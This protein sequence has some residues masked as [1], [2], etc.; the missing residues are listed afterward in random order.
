MSAAFLIQLVISAVAVA[1]LVGLAAWLG[2]PRVKGPMTDDAVRTILAEEFPDDPVGGIWLA[3]DGLS[4]VA[5]SGDQALIIY[6]VGDGHV[7]RAA[8]FREM[9][10]KRRGGG[11][12]VIH[13]GDVAAPRVRIALSDDA[14]W[15][16]KELGT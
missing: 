1:A 9:A 7:T 8:P 12:A 10:L 16:P 5:R 14:W 6:R 11:M 3:Q 15:P 4:A 2:V 13:L